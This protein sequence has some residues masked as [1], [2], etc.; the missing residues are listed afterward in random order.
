MPPMCKSVP[1]K[2][3]F[4][5]HHNVQSAVARA[6]VRRKMGLA[7]VRQAGSWGQTA[8][9]RVREAR[10]ALFGLVGC[11]GTPAGRRRPHGPS[12]KLWCQ[13]VSDIPDGDIAQVKLAVAGAP[14]AL[15]GG[16]S[17][18]QSFWC[19][20]VPNSRNQ[21]VPK[22]EILHSKFDVRFGTPVR[23]APLR[24]TRR[25]SNSRCRES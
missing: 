15:R 2:P 14:R 18:W 19:S 20:T 21:P 13:C 6:T 17:P 7:G 10:P 25:R 23:A 11:Q 1:A 9:K 5:L 3:K 8:P 12:Y 22:R 4:I 16:A 24:R